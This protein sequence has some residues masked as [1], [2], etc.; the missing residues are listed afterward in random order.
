M[1]RRRLAAASCASKRFLLAVESKPM[2]SKTMNMG[3]LIALSAAMIGTLT[4]VATAVAAPT[5]EATRVIEWGADGQHCPSVITG[6]A[7]SADGATIAAAS[8]DHVVRIWDS[9]TGELRTDSPAI[10]IGSARSRSRQTVARWPRARTTTRFVCG[11]RRPASDCRN[12]R[13]SSTPWRQFHFIPTASSSPWS[14]LATNW[15][16]ST[17]RRDN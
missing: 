13:N 8:D 12:R 14:A 16:S 5:V 6:V 4:V 15:R 1:L 9:A 10:A 17:R 2:S 11:T 3:R 7:L